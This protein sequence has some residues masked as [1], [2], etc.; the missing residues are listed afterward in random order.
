MRAR[1]VTP[2]AI[3]ARLSEIGRAKV[4]GSYENG[5]V[6]RE[7]PSRVVRTFHLETCPTTQ[8]VVEQR[9]A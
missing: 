9:C 3:V 4:G 6:A 1:W 7:T 8:P 2:P 5:W